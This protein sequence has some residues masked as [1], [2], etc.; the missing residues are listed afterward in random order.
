MKT[1]HLFLSVMSLMV[2]AFTACNKGDSGLNEQNGILKIE[3]TDAPVDDARVEG[4][5]V[6]ISDVKIDGKSLGGFSK[7][8]VDLKAYQDGRTLTLIEKELEARSYNTITLE[9]DL[10]SD[11]NGNAPGCYVR[12]NNGSKHPLGSGKISITTTHE[13][14]IATGENTELVIDFDLRKAVRRGQGAGSEYA[15]VANLNNAVRVVNKQTAGRI[16]G[17][18]NHQSTTSDH[19]VVYAYHKG[20]FN[21]TT[22]VQGSSE[23]NL[24]FH[25]AITSS[26]VGAQG[27][28][29]IHF[30]EEGEYELHFVAYDRNP[31]S[32]RL[33]LNGYLMLN[34]L[35]ALDLGSV[36]V[37]A[38]STTSVNVQ[39]TGVL[40]I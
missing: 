10:E 11:A 6:T 38:A 5:F 40:P 39:A 19:V 13:I 15:L 21:G 29:E 37:N 8:T 25:N 17:N 36:A 12:D 2:I 1:K 7:T 35:S 26:K 14:N 27:N 9:L 16:T 33:E 3:I 20:S 22:E 30:L 34:V 18:C 32:G 31:V 4:V 23:T 24:M 28:F